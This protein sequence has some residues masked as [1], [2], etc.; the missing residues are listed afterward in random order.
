M[1]ELF[2][3]QTPSLSQQNQQLSMDGVD[4]Q[5]L[6]QLYGTPSY[7]YSQT[8]LTQAVQLFQS[9]LS[10]KPNSLI[11][12][13]VKA[14]SNL[15]ILKLLADLGCGFDL[16][17]GGELQ[18][19]IRA[20]GDPRKVVFS[21]IGKTVAEI[22]L[23]LSH[24]I[25]C[26]N[27][28]SVAEL[29]RI[30][31]VAKAHGVRAPISLRVNPDVNPNTHPYISTGLKN[32]KFGVAH[33]RAIQTYENAAAHSHLDVK[34]IDCHIGSQILEIQPFLDSL[35][36]LAEL[37]S[38][39]ST[40]GI[41]LSHL[42]IG[43]GLGVSY[44]PNQEQLDPHVLYH[45]VIDRLAERGLTQQLVVEPG[46]ALVANAGV[47]LTT[48][49][50][51]KPTEHKNFAIVDAAMNDLMRPT[52]YDAYHHVIEV[53]TNTK[54]QKNLWDIVGPVCE[55]GDWLAKDRLLAIEQGDLL[56]I[57]SAGAYGFTMSSQY[58]SRLRAAEVLLH[59]GGHRLIRRRECFDDL[60]AA[61]LF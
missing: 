27:V 12:Y 46:R 25:F 48:V 8:S 34:G 54:A 35:D 28:E 39:L 44:Q 20:G 61:E 59:Q 17:S 5:Q 29:D 19:V 55:S 14:N 13:A 36:R 56:L 58:N 10:A 22:E 31:T 4:L 1:S 42:D 18:R 24:A 40:K 53:K 23:A 6:A 32:N 37:V 38:Q 51:L 47:L 41:V 43:G 3:L 30:Q 49:E 11:C 33:E 50:Y 15:Y 57:Q 9:A 52:L 45:S 2:S 26:F 60:I 7:L 21:G 16:V